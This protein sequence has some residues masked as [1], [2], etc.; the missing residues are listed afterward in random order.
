M[1]NARRSAN[2]KQRQADSA[3]HRTAKLWQLMVTSVITLH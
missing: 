1:K 2:K 3:I